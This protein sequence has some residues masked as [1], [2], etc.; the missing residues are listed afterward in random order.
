MRIGVN[1]GHTVEGA[2][3]G[4]VGLFK[5]SEHTRL[6]GNILM[7]KLSDSGANVVN[8]TIDRAETQE[9]YLVKS[10]MLANQSELDLFISIHFNAS[11]EHKGQGVEVYTYKGRKHPDALDVCARIAEMGFINRGVKDGSG[12]YVIRNTKARAMLIEVCFC[13]NEKYVDTY[14]RIGGEG[15]AN[16]IFSAIYEAMIKQNGVISEERKEQFAEFVGRIAY[17]DW[18]ER[19][20]MLPSV[21]VAQA[22]KES[23]WGASELAR[24]ANA[25]FGIRRNGWQGRIYV[26]NATEQKADG[27]YYTEEQTEWRAYD[28]WEQSV[29]DHND[30][31]ARRSADGGKTLQYAP[32]IGCDDYVLAAKYL[33]ICGYA[34]SHS[35]A[36]S[37]VRDYIEKYQLARF[38][39]F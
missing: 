22:I 16:A 38:D 32:V 8:C 23:A 30:Y 9:A 18:Q 7:K 21:V 1:C 17:R 14:Y 31:I 34:T 37:L 19:R 5:E 35:Y 10:V 36:E 2:G 12:L 28:N 33:Q 29:L 13:D 25:L 26:K 27:S 24:E 20:I 39:F 3:S 15:I 6:V 4:A 11:G